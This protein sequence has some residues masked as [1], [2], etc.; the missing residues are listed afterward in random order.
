MEK[1]EEDSGAIYHGRATGRSASREIDVT[2]DKQDRADELARWAR[3]RLVSRFYSAVRD[4][5]V[6]QIA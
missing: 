2:G 5:S 3:P 6:P 4:T 1:I